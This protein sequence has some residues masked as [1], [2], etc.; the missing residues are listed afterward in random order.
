[1]TSPIVPAA[2]KSA[3]AAVSV[4]HKSPASRRMPELDALRGLMLIGMTLTHLPTFAS[5]YFYQPMGFVAWAE[6][7]ILISAILTGKIYG[8]YL[9]SEFSGTMLQRLWKR[10]GKLYVHHIALLAI[11]FTIV[12]AIAVRTQQPA[13]LGLLDFYFAHRVVAIWSSL[14]LVYTPPLLDILPMY[15][16]F[17]LFTPFALYVG[18]RWGWRFVLIPSGLLWMG[19]Q[20]GL[21]EAIYTHL[22]HLAGVDIPMKNMGPFNTYAWQLVWAVGLWLG[23]G[24]SPRLAGWI[25][26]RWTVGFAM[27]TTL[28]FLVLRYQWTGYLS[29]H[30]VD[31]GPAWVLF[32]KWQLGIFRLVNFACLGI[33]FVRYRTNIARYFAIPPLVLLGKA[34][35]DVFSSHVVFCFAAL[36]LVGDGLSASAAQQ[37]TILVTCFLVLY[38]VAFMKKKRTVKEKRG[39]T[40]RPQP[41]E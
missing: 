19:A 5:H 30:P 25:K 36:A 4:E 14:L 29:A 20:F 39:Y 35:L 11:A 21:R 16:A 7:F 17:L 8:R 6:G 38:A 12:A 40:L 1:M 33:L 9:G 18:K 2:D 10:A 15:I 34:S 13:L 32:D 28:V 27:L 26:N 23:V 3:A 31:Q 22:V 37:W 41:Q 24:G